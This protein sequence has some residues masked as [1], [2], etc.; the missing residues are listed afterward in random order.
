[1][2][3]L[4]I[5]QEIGDNAAGLVTENL[6]K[7]WF[8]S[9]N[10][11]RVI[12]KSNANKSFSTDAIVKVN[13][14]I[15]Q[16]SAIGKILM[17]LTTKE[18]SVRRWVKKAMVTYEK[19][20]FEF[21]PQVV[22][23]MSSAA[24]FASFDLGYRISKKYHIPLALHAFDPIPS[25]IGWGENK[26]YRRAMASCVKPFYNHSTWISST[27]Q[28][29]LNYQLDTVGIRDNK[30][31]F[32]IENPSD[33]THYNLNETAKNFNFVYLG[34]LYNKRNP[35]I[36][37]NAFSD[38]CIENPSAHL[39]F[40][41]KV[42]SNLTINIPIDARNNIHFEDWTDSPQ[43]YIEQASV[44]IDID[45]DLEND[46]FI[47]SKL[48]NYLGINRL[49]LCITPPNS[50]ASQLLATIGNSVLGCNNEEL[51]ILKALKDCE[52]KST[53]TLSYKDRKEV[54]NRLKVETIIKKWTS[55]L[56]GQ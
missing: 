50:P 4:V 19:V 24:N 1:M 44:L 18:W 46:V 29:M 21:K 48:T 11:I 54:R 45:A 43:K 7:G 22:L 35:Q 8:N 56:N 9:N 36:L 34:N 47:S 5:V 42:S 31:T 55:Y 23:A 28:S 25:T 49:I 39:F 38:Y 40:V 26:Y 41:G 2:N 20:F 16:R 27:N 6:L 37:I 15:P 10:D 14:M 13:E 3:I 51:L 32:V 30:V 33:Q 53:S 12:C 17:I 52:S